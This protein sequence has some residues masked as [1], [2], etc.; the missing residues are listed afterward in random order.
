MQFREPVQASCAGAILHIVRMERHRDLVAKSSAVRLMVLAVDRLRKDE[1]VQERCCDALANIT[2]SDECVIPVYE[3]G[4]A[5]PLLVTLH[6]HI[7][8][9]VII[10]PALRTLRH[11]C[12]LQPCVEW[13]SGHGGVEVICKTIESHP[14]D[15]G[16]LTSACVILAD[17]C[18][19][20]ELCNDAVQ[21]G[22]LT[23]T[24][25]AMIRHSSDAPLVSAACAVLAA[26]AVIPTL[27]N[28]IVQN[29]GLQRL[30]AAMQRHGRD[31]AL[32]TNAVTTLCQLVQHTGPGI[33]TPVIEG[34]FI[35][36]VF[37][38]MDRLPAATVLQARGLGFMYGLAGY[39][40]GRK[41]LQA[42]GAEARV[43][44]T[45]VF[46]SRNADVILWAGRALKRLTP[47]C[48][49]CCMQ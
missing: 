38:A 34:G 39:R 40:G 20:E 28:R 27:A 1:T 32:M 25:Q 31:A 33:G 24:F 49:G 12:A 35:E 29:K 21:A 41:Q 30:A 18:L 7:A 9:P 47:W 3:A 4:C 48:D 23:C 13:V 42:R 37:V 44:K 8:N 26:L 11:L 15:V 46:N 6:D 14:D 10:T 45:R 19:T 2:S 36:R 16:V 17:L 22:G 43:H 5:P